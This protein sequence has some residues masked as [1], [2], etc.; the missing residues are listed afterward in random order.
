MDISGSANKNL[1]FTKDHEWIEFQGTIARIG[2]CSFKLLG[3][4]EIHDIVFYDPIGMQIK[5]GE[6]IAKVKSKDFSIGAH[7]PVDGKLIKLNEL[8]VSG[9]R[10]ILLR[11]PESIGWIAMIAPSQPYERKDILAPKEYRLN[12]KGKYAK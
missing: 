6:L 3:F 7:M 2:I 8:L 4:R 11:Y 1:F 5:K 9:D 12:R 10:N